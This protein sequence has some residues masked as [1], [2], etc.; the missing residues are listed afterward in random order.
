MN[1]HISILATSELTGDRRIPDR[2]N[3]PHDLMEV[4]AEM[5]AYLVAMRNGLKPRS[6]SY[7][8]GYEGAFNDLDL[9]SVS[10][11][12]NAVERLLGI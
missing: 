4:E 3:T 1:S 12:A 8:S 9:Y 5:S 7:L 6:E 11:T 10:R 2:R